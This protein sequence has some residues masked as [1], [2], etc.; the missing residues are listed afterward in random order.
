VTITRRKF[1]PPASPFD[2][3]STLRPPLETLLASIE[4]HQSSWSW[5]KAARLR[6]SFPAA[7]SMSAGF[8]TFTR[9]HRAEFSW[10][11]TPGSPI[12]F[13]QTFSR[14]GSNQTSSYSGATKNRQP[15]PSPKYFTI[16]GH[17]S[18][19]WKACSGTK[20][21]SPVGNSSPD[22]IYHPVVSP[23]GGWRRPFTGNCAGSKILL[24]PI[25]RWSSDAR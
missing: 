14:L 11:P 19:K 15:D 20:E 8:A 6:L 2:D 5:R 16:S 9:S 1:S 25:L 22:Q 12:S 4:A 21:S 13:A 3:K 24:M 17:L 23:S 10:L 7:A 18:F